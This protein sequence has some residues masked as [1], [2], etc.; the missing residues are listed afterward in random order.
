MLPQREL[1]E[2]IGELGRANEALRD[3]LAR[4]DRATR[5][6]GEGVEAGESVA[7][8]LERANGIVALRDVR[9]ALEHWESVRRDVRVLLLALAHEEGIS[10]AEMG[11]RLGF[12]RQLASRLSADALGLHGREPGAD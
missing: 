10:M 5:T 3:I 11:R 1:L 6:L 4:L 7:E 8:A 12:S 2:K 9:T